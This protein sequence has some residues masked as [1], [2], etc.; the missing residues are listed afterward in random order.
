MQTLDSSGKNGPRERLVRAD[1]RVTYDAQC[2]VK[3][4]LFDLYV[5]AVV[6]QSND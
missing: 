1:L 2:Q 3:D 5:Y 4:N 6:T